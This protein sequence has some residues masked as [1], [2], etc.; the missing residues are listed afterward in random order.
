MQHRPIKV[1]LVESDESY[2]DRLRDDLGEGQRDSLQLEHA[3][4]LSQA[5]AKLSQGGFDAV[6]LSLDLTDSQGMVTFDRMY[7]FAPD[8][9]I[10]VL[11]READE[12]A[13]VAA[14]QG[15]AQDHL[16]KPEITAGMLVRTVRHAIERHRLFTALRSLSLIDDL[17]GLYNRRFFRRYL[18][19]EFRRALRYQRPLT[20]AILDLDHFKA[21]N[22][23]NGHEAGNRALQKIGEILRTSFRN[24]DIACR[25]G[26]EEFAVILPETDKG[27]GFVPD[28]EDE[29]VGAFRFLE[30]VRARI[31]EEA[32]ENEDRLPTGKLTISGGVASYPADAET[33]EG[34][35]DAADKSLYLAKAEG[36]NRVYLA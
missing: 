1:L 19:R 22:D 6:L 36:K 16:A 10:I 32:F 7:A 9:P 28:D 27:A 34:L 23:L 8:V 29:S 20:L 15:G 2:A 18:D 31:E 17:T 11:T 13:A 14:V 5:L 25:Y 33:V 12:E 24:T 3:E 35:L 21:F 30:R 4:E 26:G